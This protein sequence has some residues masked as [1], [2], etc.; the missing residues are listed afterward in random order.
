MKSIKNLGPG[1][2]FWPFNYC[3]NWY[4]PNREWYKHFVQ[5]FRF[6][7]VF[8]IKTYQNWNWFRPV[9]SYRS[10]FYLIK[11]LWGNCL[12]KMVFYKILLNILTLNQRRHFLRKHYDM[13]NM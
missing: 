9:T 11:L 8:L 1:P 2:F 5:T 10:S 3:I 13:R 6:L 7:N 12:S 4:H